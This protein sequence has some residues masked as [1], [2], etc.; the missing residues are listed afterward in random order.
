MK[1][2]ETGQD[3][4]IAA[5]RSSFHVH[6][7]F[8]RNFMDLKF[9]DKAFNYAKKAYDLNEV[10]IGAVI[11][12]DDKII[13]FGFNTKESSNCSINHAEI[14]AIKRAQKKLNNWRLIDC[15]IYVT[16]DPCPMCASAIKQARI[17]NVYSA[18]ENSDVNNYKLINEIFKSDST[19][20]SVNFFSNLDVDKARL[21][22]NDFFEKQRKS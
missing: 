5:L 10:P 3:W 20:P 2:I 21:L 6:F 9:M 11:V 19:N 7:L 13:S 18:V 12:K 4:E 17:S 14:L 8:W 22:L 16:L 15:D 1:V